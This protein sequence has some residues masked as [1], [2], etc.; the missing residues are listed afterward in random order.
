MNLSPVLTGPGAGAGRCYDEEIHKH[1]ETGWKS[2]Q[3]LSRV[4][5]QDADGSNLE[6]KARAAPKMAKRAFGV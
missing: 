6:T 3:E 2:E 4:Y 1:L 5:F